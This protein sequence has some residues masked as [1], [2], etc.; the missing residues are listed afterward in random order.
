MPTLEEISAQATK[1]HEEC[2]RECIELDYAFKV[3]KL[4][5]WVD[6]KYERMMATAYGRQPTGGTDP[7]A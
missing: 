1:Q 5:E 3:G 2:V 7:A 4:A 6:R